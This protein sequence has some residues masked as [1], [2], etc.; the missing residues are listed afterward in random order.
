MVGQLVIM[1][2]GGLGANLKSQ[3]PARKY[4]KGKMEASSFK[5]T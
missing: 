5:Y 3:Q 2:L 4:R 1:C